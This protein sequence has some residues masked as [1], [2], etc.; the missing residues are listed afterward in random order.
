MKHIC[1][2]RAVRLWCGFGFTILLMILIINIAAAEMTSYNLS[3]STYH[4]GRGEGARDVAVD[5]AG[6]VYV[7]GGVISG[8]PVTANA[9]DKTANGNSDVFISKFDAD[10]R[11]I[12]STYLGGPNYD[13]AYAIEVDPKG[14]VYVAG[15]A[16]KKFPTTPGVVQPNFGGDV[17]PNKIYGAQDAF[18]AKL[19]PDGS[20]LI[21]STYF[22]S[23][24]NEI[25]R[26]MDIDN[27]GNV[28]LGLTGTSRN[29]PHI[30]QKAFKVK[31][32]R[33]DAAVA[34][35][36]N[37]AS[38]VIY[39]TY[40]GGSDFDGETPSLRVDNNGYAYVL[41]GA[42]SVDAPIIPDAFDTTY[43]GGK[44][45][46]LVTKLS[47]D[48]SSLIFST[49]LGGSGYEGIETH[50]LAIDDYG[51]VYIYFLT[52]SPDLPVTSNAF[53][54]AYVGGTGRYPW[55]VY[56]SKL[57]YDGTKL[58]AAT[59][60]GGSREEAA[61]GIA[62][63]DKGNVYLSGTTKSPDFPVTD[64]A[65]N[66]SLNGVQDGFFAKF[67]T[68]FSRLM[69][70]TYIGGSQKDSL[71][72]IDRVKT[73]AVALCGGSES[74]NFPLFRAQQ[75]KPGNQVVILFTP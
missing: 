30:T 46:M 50:G 13:R 16:G 21:W 75:T 54:S 37:D 6:N 35:L 17:E 74:K 55:D 47:P 51:H 12:W 61:E 56:V 53:S 27:K 9:Y 40:L 32:G 34:K 72:S 3:F 69:Y 49:F 68:Q 5:G 39:C 45:D 2:Y 14:Y 1:T 22:G 63:D 65:F 48:G 19:S 28:Y 7:T 58:L 26:D 8:L 60:L 73:G 71:R 20:K 10:G 67:N 18:A 44:R 41:M 36:S 31:H 57:S 64:N 43:N 42:A 4:G 52:N 66:N 62:V 24:G 11:L 70:S 29:N 25:A 15:R 38:T 33:E 23:D 59:Y